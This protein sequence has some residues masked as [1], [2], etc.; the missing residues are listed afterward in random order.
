MC[1]GSKAKEG[2]FLA[3]GER[4]LQDLIGLL[5]GATSRADLIDS[6]R[7]L[8]D[9]FNLD[10]VIYHSVNGAGEQYAALTYSDEWVGHYLATD[11]GR[12]DPVLRGA[13]GRFHPVPWKELDWS[14]KAARDFLGEAMA[15]GVGNQGL[16]VPIRG[17]SG[18]FALFSLN[19]TASD[20]AW[21][22][23]CREHM[24]DLILLGHYLNQKAL[25][26]D[27]GTDITP[28]QR[29]SPRE[30]DALSLLASGLNRAQAADTLRISEHT[31]RVYVEGARFKLG[32]NNTT[33]A[34][35]RALNLGLLMI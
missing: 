14:G 9:A 8:R 29:L 5:D 3:H 31:L 28:T 22:R 20:D 12:V 24:S 1:R 25:E 33:H 11:M 6:V 15:N 23:I 32:A 26:I 21:E 10:H 13:Y 19:H 7:V 4:R 35:A 16:T 34:V 27:Q 17:P 30:I 18:Q 2:R